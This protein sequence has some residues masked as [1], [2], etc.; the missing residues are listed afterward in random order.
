MGSSL[1]FGG[2]DPKSYSLTFG[3]TFGGANTVNTWTSWNLIPTTPPMIPAPEP[4][5]N[6]IDIPGRRLG[7][8]DLSLF[9]FNRITYKRITGSW[10]F[11]CDSWPAWV[12][13][14]AY[15]VGDAVIR[16]NI[17]YVC[18]TANSNQSFVSAN[19]DACTD[20]DLVKVLYQRIRSYLH[21]KTTTVE[22]YEDR[23]HYFHGRFIVGLP[24]RSKNPISI[25]IGYDLEPMRYN[26]NGTIDSTWVVES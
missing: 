17:P 15:K 18:K 22:L 5:V 14:T 25:S 21:G 3:G 13:G 23:T 19:W 1:T 9:P 12:G 24:S 4:N 16:N 26:Q 10:D 8:I 11:L 20:A 7:P 6:Q 2:V